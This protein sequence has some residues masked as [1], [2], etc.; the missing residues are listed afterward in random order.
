MER[1][2]PYSWY[3]DPEI[4][5]REQERIFRSAWQYAG[6]RRRSAGARDVLRRAR[7]SHAGRRHPR[8]RRRASGVPERLPPPRL[9]G[10]RGSR[11]AR[12]AAV[13]VP[14]L[15]VRSRRRAAR[16][17]AR[18]GARGLRRGR[19]RALPR[20]DRYL[21]P[22]R[23]RERAARAG[24]AGGCARLDACAGG[25]ARARRRRPR[26]LHALAD[27]GRGE[28]EGRLRELPRVLPL[29]GRASAAR[30]DARRVGRRVRALDRR[31]AVEPARPDPRDRGD[32]DAPRRRAAA[33]PVPLPL[34]EPRREHLPGPAEHLDRPDR[35]ALARPHVPLPRLLLRARR[36]PGR[37]STS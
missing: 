18:G 15:D 7:R 9:P 32:E 14:R 37:G 25:R 23:V 35:A 29:L 22:V 19:A 24:A 3:V 30:G 2:L 1:T 27:R 28:L 34:A 4:L 11:Q 33:Q 6:P 5:R 16:S 31:P 36:R 17:A 21:G 10:R 20:R 8:A 26:L 13:P 12:D